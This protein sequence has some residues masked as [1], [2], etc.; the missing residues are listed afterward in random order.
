[1]ENIPCSD[2]LAKDLDDEQIRAVCAPL[3]NM[4]VVAIAGSGK[5]RVLTYRVANLI[6]NGFPERE[7]MLLTFTNKA[8]GEMIRRIQSI[9]GKPKLNLLAGTFHSIASRFLRKYALL[10]G[11]DKEFSI[12][13]ASTQKN[14]MD[15]CRDDYLASYESETEEFP[16]TNVLTGIYSGAINHNMT[17]AEYIKEYYHY[18][19]G[20]VVDGILLIFGDYVEKK[21]ADSLMDFDDLLLNFYDILQVREAREEITS[22]FKYIFV[23]EYQDIN[24]VQNEILRLLNQNEVMFVIGDPYQC[25]YQFRGSD[26]EYI[27]QFQQKEQNYRLTYNYRSTPEILQ[28]AEDVINHNDTEHMIC[29]NTKNEPFSAPLIFGTEDEKQEIERMASI[30]KKNYSDSLKDVAVLVRKGNQINMVQQVFE[31]NGLKCDLMVSKGFFEM[32]HIQNLITLMQIKTG[33][34]KRAIFTTAA[35]LFRG[36]TEHEAYEMWEIFKKAGYNFYKAK[37][38]NAKQANAFS[39]LG[40]IADYREKDTSDLISYI[41]DI[42]YKQYV[43]NRYD[44]A[45]EKYEDI[46]YLMQITKGNTD[47]DKFLD[48]ISLDHVKEK[49][50][51]GSVKITT[52]HKA[53][54]LEWD[55]VFIPFMDK[56]EFPRCRDSDYLNN[57]FNVQNERNLFYV[58]ITR[59]RKQI[60]LSYSMKYQEKPCGMSP[61]MEVEFDPEGYDAV[62]FNK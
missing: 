12:L 59:A 51:S 23:D 19:N 45:G 18:Y 36:V 39:K 17:F 60:V 55:Y 49:P 53:K 43:F 37:G 21:E 50:S 41:C 40:T 57:A 33:H 47:L 30:I 62:F 58:A 31:A 9:L 16:S 3:C 29:L 38:N 32:Y 46:E 48:A 2:A 5:T 42:F 7:M 25:I 27:K 24:W 52:M 10:I 54:G 44:N 4:C 61:F 13:N 14:L 56:G 20:K 26:E 1:M 35:R 34:K 15:K 6:D 8:A 22:R 11:Y 28:L